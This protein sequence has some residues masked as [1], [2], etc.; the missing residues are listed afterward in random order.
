M[1]FVHI[2]HCPNE[3]LVL[4]VNIKLMKMVKIATIISKWLNF[5]HYE[6]NNIF[7]GAVLP[8]LS[9]LVKAVVSL[10]FVCLKWK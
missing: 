8:W 2:R 1:S 10:F 3:N 5:I 9:I 7:A 4:I 6:S